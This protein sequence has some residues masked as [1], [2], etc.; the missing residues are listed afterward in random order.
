[1]RSLLRHYRAW[2]EGLGGIGRG[3]S[4]VPNVAIL[5]AWLK[6]GVAG[7]E[8]ELIRVRGEVVIHGRVHVILGEHVGLPLAH[9]DICVRGLVPWSARQSHRVR[10]SHSVVARREWKAVRSAVVRCAGGA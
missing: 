4:L 7:A 5:E 8:V 6:R 1:V 2:L 3:G 10:A 9:I